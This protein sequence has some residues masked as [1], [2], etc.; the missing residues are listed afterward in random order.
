VVT[1]LRSRHAKQMLCKC[2]HSLA[3]HRTPP[4]PCSD[5]FLKEAVRLMQERGYAIGNIDCTII[6]EVSEGQGGVPVACQL[7]AKQPDS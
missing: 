6:A 1:S 7:C 5:V 3:L 4:Y 2:S